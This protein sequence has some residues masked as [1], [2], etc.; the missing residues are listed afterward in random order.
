MPKKGMILGPLNGLTREPLT[1]TGILPL[2][3]REAYGLI[4]SL[5]F[6]WVVIFGG[7]SAL[8]P[9]LPLVRSEFQ[10]SGS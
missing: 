1:A 6:G 9:L 7:I 5:A 4:S 3:R 10:L 8:Y 2:S